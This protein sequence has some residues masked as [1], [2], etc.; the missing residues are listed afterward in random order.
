MV[1][2]PTTEIIEPIRKTETLCPVFFIRSK[3]SNKKKA[4]SIK[5]DFFFLYHTGPQVLDDLTHW[6]IVINQ[7]T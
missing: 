6:K 5:E 2:L 1:V 3:S 7:K 4:P